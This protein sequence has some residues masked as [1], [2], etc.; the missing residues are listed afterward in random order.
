[1][2]FGFDGDRR[3]FIGLVRSSEARKSRAAEAL[4]FF[5][6]QQDD[7]TLA[8]I[9]RRFASSDSFRIFTVNMVRK[10][11]NRRATAYRIPPIRTFEG[12]DQE[13]G[14]ALYQAANIDAVMKRASKLTKLLKTSALQVRHSDHG[15]QVSVLT[16]HILDAV[17][18]DP[19]HPQRI[20]V[21]HA[22]SDTTRTTYSDWTAT[23]YQRRDHQGR[24]ISN[25]GNP[26]GVNP[27]GLLP[28]VPLFDRLPDSSFFLPGGD[29]LIGAQKALNVGLANLFRSIELQ[30]HGQAVA[31]GLPIGDPIATGPD[32]VILLP[33]DGEF[34]Y[35]S[36]NAPITEMLSAL[37]FLMRQTAATNDVGADVF[38][39]SKR[40]ESGSAKHA[41][42][43]DLREAR[44]DDIALWRRYEVRLFEVIKAVVNAHAPGTIPEA[45]TIRVDF[46]ELQDNL[47][48]AELLENL[49]VKAELGISS[50][51]DALMAM[52]PDGFVTRD[53]AYRELQRRKAE[54]QELLLAL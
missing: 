10:V 27:Y 45:A 51:V 42:R 20:V 40:A 17:Y 1:M 47:T 8:L 36:P 15:L 37:E 35:A 19:E 11:V 24:V 48:E 53:E 5:D 26:S 3:D 46:A 31:K 49:K 14:T 21:T 39:L 16:P 34:S 23:T 32:K 29:D 2:L 28:F 54:T 7:T 50:P 18:D 43:L 30:A 25:S 9:K 12:W 38:D 41:E 6:D 4:N 33:P 52:N 44:Q 22:A 13:A